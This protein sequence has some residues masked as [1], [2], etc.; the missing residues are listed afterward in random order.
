MR[1]EDGWDHQEPGRKSDVDWEMLG[2]LEFACGMTLGVGLL[3]MAL[4]EVCIIQE[5]CTRG[6]M[7]TLIS[8][9]RLPGQT[10][11][12]TPPDLGVALGLAY[13]VAA[14]MQHIHDLQVRKPGPL[15]VCNGVLQMQQP[16]N[17]LRYPEDSLGVD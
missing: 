16:T 1:L 6:S 3:Q 5:Y 2:E 14:G 17:L 8:E 15:I 4:Y 10:G 11:V 13:D 12:G 9:G 7:Y